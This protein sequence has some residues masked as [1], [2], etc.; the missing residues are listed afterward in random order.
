[1]PI[2]PIICFPL[3]ST[4]GNLLMLTNRCFNHIWH[5]F[6]FSIVREQLMKMN[7]LPQH[8]FQPIA[9]WILLDPIKPRVLLQGCPCV[10]YTS[11][12]CTVFSKYRLPILS[13]SVCFLLFSKMNPRYEEHKMFL[14]SDV[15]LSGIIT[16]LEYLKTWFA[17]KTV[18]THVNNGHFDS[19]N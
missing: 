6:C 16:R 13:R 12:A 18:F 14:E 2:I 4:K 10:K 17:L 9:I 3:S 8:N 5:W 15:I 1:M 19:M 11:L 7:S